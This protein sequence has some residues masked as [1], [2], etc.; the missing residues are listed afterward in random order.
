M[1]EEEEKEV[2]TTGAGAF[3]GMIAGASIGLLGGPA[4]VI[5]GG[6]IGALLGDQ[7]ELEQRKKEREEEN[8]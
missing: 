8:W 1:T 3:A 7:Y 5:I 2:E 4:G 6:L